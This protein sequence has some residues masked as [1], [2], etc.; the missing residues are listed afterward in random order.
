MLVSV[1]LVGSCAGAAG[2][3]CAGVGSV[4]TG[5]CWCVRHTCQ[6]WCW[7]WH[8]HWP[9]HMDPTGA[10]VAA[11]GGVASSRTGNKFLLD[12]LHSDK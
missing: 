7:W 5:Q 2:G 11:S 12:T 8:W 3:V 6:W 4:G 1:V 10:A 9:G